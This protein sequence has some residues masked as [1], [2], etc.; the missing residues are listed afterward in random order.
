MQFSRVAVEHGNS[1]DIVLNDT[2]NPH[3]KTYKQGDE[4]LNIALPDF[5]VVRFDLCRHCQL[6]I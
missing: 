1:E 3:V 2:S 4:E 5:I 6:Y